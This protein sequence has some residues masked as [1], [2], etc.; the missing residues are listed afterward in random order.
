MDKFART[1]RNTKK[2]GRWPGEKKADLY[3]LMLRS[4][5]ARMPFV[6]LGYYLEA[7]VEHL[8]KEVNVAR[9]KWILLATETE[10]DLA[11]VH[12]VNLKII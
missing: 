6:P 7:D 9:L 3:S 12:G 8:S 10:L 2:P 4:R 1:S 5:V 11:F